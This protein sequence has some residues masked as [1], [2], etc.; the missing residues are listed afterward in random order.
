MSG[1]DPHGSAPFDVPVDVLLSRIGRVEQEMRTEEDV[2]GVLPCLSLTYED[3]LLR[4]G[5]RQSALDRVFALLELPSVP[6]S[7]RYVRLSSDNLAT[8]VR[9][10]DEIRRALAGTRYERFLGEP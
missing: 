1:D 4:E 8:V 10:H 3:D 5:T 6:V 9:N 2:L 7:T